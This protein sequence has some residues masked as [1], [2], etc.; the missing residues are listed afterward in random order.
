MDNKPRVSVVVSFLNAERFLEEAIQ[1]VFAQTFTAWELL[2]VDDGSSDS[3]AE[4]ALRYSAE[5][6]HLVRYLEHSNHCNRG[7][8]ASRNFGMGS[9]R[10]DFIALL[11]SDDV[12]LPHK[13]EQQVAILD[14]H[15]RVSLVFGAT[16]YWHSW[17]GS[18]SNFEP[19]SVE[20]PG[21]PTN[22]IYEPPELLKLTLSGAAISPCPSDLMFRKESI[23]SLGGFEESFIGLFSMYEDQAFLSKVFTDLAVYVSDEWW[24]RYRIHSN[25]LCAKVI[26]SGKKSAVTCVYLNWVEEYLTRKGALD[27]ETKDIIRRQL[28]P[29][30][31]PLLNRLIHV[32][33]AVTRR[34][35]RIGTSLIHRRA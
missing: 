12:W 19:D 22:R 30:E 18:K 10:G 4:I 6:P 15:P 11:D 27:A 25:Q 8:P 23:R 31:H 7:L 34:I 24:D 33:P 5:Y 21:V 35:K 9:A 1:S 26:R 29:L 20:A 28:W 3:S 14:S 32:G 16:Q 17:E 13:L 2:L